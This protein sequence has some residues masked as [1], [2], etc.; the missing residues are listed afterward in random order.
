MS[1]RY[2]L[3]S[4]EINAPVKVLLIEFFFNQQVT[5]SALLRWALQ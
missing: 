4:Y 3:I 2:R 5:F 1:S